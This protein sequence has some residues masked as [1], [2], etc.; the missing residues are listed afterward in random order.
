MKRQSEHRN[1]TSDHLIDRLTHINHFRERVFR[2]STRLSDILLRS[3]ISSQAVES[4]KKNHLEAVVEEV[5]RNL[6]AYLMDVLPPK[7]AHVVAERF[8]LNGPVQP[9]LQV[10][11]DELDLSRERILQ[12]QNKGMRRL[13][14]PARRA[15][16]DEIIVSS[17]MNVQSSIEAEV[18]AT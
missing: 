2:E 12:L 7:R 16:I 3:G 14:P 4:I 11:A 1:R 6:V 15:A 18:G 17:A 13:G 9:T 8:S 5:C 10:I